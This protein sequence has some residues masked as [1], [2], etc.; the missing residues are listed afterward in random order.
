MKV[1]QTPQLKDITEYDKDVGIEGR[2]HHV[3]EEHHR[4]GLLLFDDIYGSGATGRHIVDA[5]KNLSELVDADEVRDLFIRLQSGT[6][7]TRQQIRDAWPGTIGPFIVRLAGK[8]DSTPS[9]K[10]FK[11]IDRRSRGDAKRR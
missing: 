10:L 8:M 2:F 7:L 1:K 4:Q 5:P 3:A 11:Q 6:A 9:I